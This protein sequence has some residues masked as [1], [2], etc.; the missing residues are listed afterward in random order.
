MASKKDIFLIPPVSTNPRWKSA[1]EQQLLDAIHGVYRHIMDYSHQTDFT[2]QTNLY[3]WLVSPTLNGGVSDQFL[4][5]SPCIRAELI[6]L[7]ISYACSICWSIH[8]A[9]V[10]KSSTLTQNQYRAFLKRL[11]SA[12]FVLRDVAKPQIIAWTQIPQIP[13]VAECSIDTIDFLISLCVSIYSLCVCLLSVCDSRKIE[14]KAW[15][16]MTLYTAERF[17]VSYSILHKRIWPMY[18]CQHPS[19]WEMSCALSGYAL[20]YRSTSYFALINN[21]DYADILTT[22]ELISL[23]RCTEYLMIP[24]MNPMFGFNGDTITKNIEDTKDI[25]QNNLPLCD[26]PVVGINKIDNGEEWDRMFSIVKKSNKLPES[27]D[28]MAMLVSKFPIPYFVLDPQYGNYNISEHSTSST[29][30]HKSGTRKARFH[31]KDIDTDVQ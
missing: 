27:Q 10:E 16:R 25:I 19:A 31:M 8:H 18:G 1:T 5:T 4:F 22:R 11:W 17:E 21:Y 23:A 26:H 28:L 12:Y 6:F 7:C 15:S 30:I 9:V 2:F 24:L 20:Y 13:P 29:K 14:S 3:G